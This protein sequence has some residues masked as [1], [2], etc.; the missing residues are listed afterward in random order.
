M[1]ASKHC[2]AVTK[3]PNRT[4]AACAEESILT[5]A[6]IA[7]V[8]RAAGTSPSASPHARCSCT[9]TGS[10][11]HPPGH[12]PSAPVM[13]RTVPPS[14]PRRRGWICAIPPSLSAACSSRCIAIARGVGCSN[15]IVGDSATPVSERRRDE[16]SVAASE[17]TP[18]SISG[19][20]ARTEA[21]GAPVSSRTIRNTNASTCV[22]RCMVDRLTREFASTVPAAGAVL[23]A[24]GPKLAGTHFVCARNSPK[25]GCDL[26]ARSFSS[27]RTSE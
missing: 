8:H 23:S 22:R 19:V 5:S 9:R 1:R 18:A 12:W 7:S 25:R 17:S 24:T 15:T 6:T 10:A 11:L 4:H 2:A 14:V 16:S 13:A 26:S 27:L 21:A 3:P 20:S